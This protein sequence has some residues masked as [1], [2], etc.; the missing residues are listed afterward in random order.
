M[1]FQRFIKSC[2]GTGAACAVLGMWA[3]AASAVYLEPPVGYL[4]FADSPFQPLVP[5]FS[6][7]HLQTWE[8][9]PT[10]SNVGATASAGLVLGPGSLIDSVDGGGNNGHSWFSGCGSCGVTFTFNAGVLGNLPTHA[11]IVWTDGELNIHFTAFDQNGVSLGTIDDSRGHGFSLG[12]GDPDNYRFYGAENAGG[13]SKITVSNDGGGI[14]LDHLQ[15][16][17]AAAVPE[18]ETDVML[19]SGLALLGFEARRRRLNP[20]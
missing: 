14:E 18:P 17:F 11:G 6:Y 13:I 10:D 7:F 16:G 8:G 15:Y 2:V 5:T 4:S 1:G 19:L 3:P 20:A 9:L 12:D